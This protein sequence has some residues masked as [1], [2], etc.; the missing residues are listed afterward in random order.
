MIFGVAP[1]A[2]AVRRA[3]AVRWW[4]A[5]VLKNDIENSDEKSREIGAFISGPLYN[6]RNA[7]FASARLIC[8]DVQSFPR[9]D[10]ARSGVA[11]RPR[12]AD[13]TF[14]ARAHRLCDG[15]AVCA[16]Q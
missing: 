2:F 12:P 5:L 4:V 7:S 13:R 9:R 15:G 6:G 10:N 11:D 8:C 3:S 1:G 16:A 14:H